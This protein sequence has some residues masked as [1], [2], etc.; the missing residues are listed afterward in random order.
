MPRQGG[1]FNA[2]VSPPIWLNLP[3][4]RVWVYRADPAALGRGE[5]DLIDRLKEQADRFREEWRERAEKVRGDL[6]E[7]TDRVRRSA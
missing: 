1:G 7:K 5:Q 3:P 6:R 2:E 4:A